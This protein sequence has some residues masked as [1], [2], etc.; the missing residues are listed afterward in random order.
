MFRYVSSACWNSSASYFNK[1]ELKY[2]SGFSIFST[3]SG[4]WSLHANPHDFDSSSISSRSLFLRKVFASNLAHLSVILTWLSGMHFH[5]AYFGNYSAW[6]KDPLHVLPSSQSV[7]DIVGQDILNGDVG[8]SHQGIY[9]T[10][11]LFQLW[12]SSGIINL[13]Q[14]KIIAISLQIL[15]FFLLLG[16]Y[17]H[18]NFLQYPTHSTYMKLRSINTH[19]LVLL[20]GIGSISWAGHQVHVSI[21]T[22]RLL[23]SGIDPSL[24][25]TPA[26]LISNGSMSDLYPNFGVSPLP[27]FSWSLPANIRLLAD[28]GELDPHSGS[29]YL[30]QIAAHHFY[31]GVTLILAG[32]ALKPS[33]F[34]STGLASIS[35]R[36]SRLSS[37]ATLS[38]SLA[39]TGS[40]SLVTS[41][42]LSAIPVY[43]LFVSDYPTALSSFVHHM[44]IGSILIVGAGSHASIHIVRD[45]YTPDKTLLKSDYMS[46]LIA[47]REVLI[48]HL[49]WVT[50]FLGTH[51]FGIYLHNDTL[52]SLGRPEDIISDNGIQ[53]KP[54]FANLLWEL[55]GGG[56]K[57]Y[58]NVMDSRVS[59]SW[60]ELGTSDFL[61]HHIH[62]FTI[63][64]TLLILVKGVLNSRS[65]RL[66]ADKSLLGFR[67]PCDGPGRGGTCQISPWDHVFLSLFWAYNT[68]SVVV[69]HFY[70][71]M[72][73]DVWGVYNAQSSSI[74]HIT[75]G[76]FSVSSGT[77]NAW[78]TNFLWS[79]ASQV[80][81]SYGTSNS[82]YGL[83]F[84]LAHF[85]WAL[86]LMFLYSG[87]G[88]WQ[89][90]IESILWAHTKLHISV[91][92]Q[93]RA[94][95]ITQGRSVGVVHYILGGILTTWSFTLSRIV[96]IT[97]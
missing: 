23:D 56:S 17:I 22:C 7:W 14:L 18:M 66:V 94:L 31:V 95:S 19:H 91:S 90:L 2:S 47:H 82:G 50:I 63:H 87:R 36:G 32:L 92:I 86:S 79:Q 57:I 58:V 40:L 33:L 55:R 65:S 41:H 67:Y 44:W 34:G 24:L 51:S 3:T 78:L 4:I 59:T 11:G 42:H 16:A 96:A 46:L 10:S 61:V 49:A 69:F 20:L 27:D 38:I 75:G 88:Y 60:Q 62:A 35:N 13:Y 76:D 6:L 68:I 52:Q 39:I 28:L 8:A 83:T 21:P 5:A 97:S 25:P 9:I 45:Y 53:L 85:T 84:L 72:Q 93:P 29:I 80:I 70:W 73:S 64:V 30:G 74:D 15:A 71:K 1:Q 43:P 81:Q 54:I 26:N 37:H 48:G 12:R 89:E 77:I